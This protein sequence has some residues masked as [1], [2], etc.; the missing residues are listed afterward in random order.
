MMFRDS[1]NGAC[2]KMIT[3]LCRVSFSA[4]SAYPPSNTEIRTAQPSHPVLNGVL[5]RPLPLSI[6]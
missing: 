3:S 5:R 2:L 6:H 4:E 1:T